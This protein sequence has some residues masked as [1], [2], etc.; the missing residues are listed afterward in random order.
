MSSAASG[1]SSG[2]VTA[3]P[4]AP[5]TR[6]SDADFVLASRHLLG[7]GTATTIAT[8]LCPCGAIDVEHSDHAMT[9]KQTAGM[10]TLRNDICASARRRAIGCA[11]RATS[12]EPSYSKLLAA[13]Q[14]GGAAGF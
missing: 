9:C 8:Q 13:G 7:L 6:L 11:G 12:S 5:S 10:A 4:G 2:W 1:P 14:R 3:L